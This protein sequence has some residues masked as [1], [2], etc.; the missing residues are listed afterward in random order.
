MARS[1]LAR[2]PAV[3][4]ASSVSSPGDGGC[5]CDGA[6]NAAMS[7]AVIT[8]RASTRRVMPGP[9][10]I[11][12]FAASS[13]GR[14]GSGTTGRTSSSRDLGWRHPSITRTASRCRDRPGGF[15]RTGSAGSTETRRAAT[16]GP[17]PRP[18]VP[19]HCAAAAKR[20]STPNG[21]GFGSQRYGM[22]QGP[23]IR[24]AGAIRGRAPTAVSD[25][26]RKAWARLP[27]R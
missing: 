1:F 6:R 16:H 7:V 18:R 10:V 22:G 11:P 27:R 4:G 20:G 13:R 25:R 2:S 14:S 12:S 21:R 5:T 23:E 24:P 15:R 17:E 19:P 3:L 26:V 9:P 8:L